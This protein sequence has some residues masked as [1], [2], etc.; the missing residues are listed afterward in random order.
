MNLPSTQN[1]PLLTR[2]GIVTLISVLA[3]LLVKTGGGSVSTWLN[4]NAD[5]I[6][7]LILMAGPIVTGLLARGKVTPTANIPTG[8]IPTPTAT[9]AALP[10]SDTAALLEQAAAISSATP[11]GFM[12]GS[13]TNSAASVDAPVTFTTGSPA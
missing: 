4:Q 3:S 1:E 6:A 13:S 5:T 8:V 7:L 11:N 2:A 12:G 9:V 10:T